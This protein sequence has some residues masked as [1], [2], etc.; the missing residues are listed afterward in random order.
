MTT[1]PSIPELIRR[2]K[3]LAALDLI[4]SP[5][6]DMR[7][8]SFNSTWSAS[9]QMA[10]MRDGCG[11]EWWMVFHAD[12]WTALKG[13]GHESP[14]WSEGGDSLSIALQQTFPSELAEFSH[15]PAFRWDSTS[16]AAFCLPA[17]RDWVWSKPLTQFSKL[18]GGEDELLALLSGSPQD[19]AD[20]ASQYYEADVPVK[21]VQ[22]VFSL[23]PITEDVVLA[24]NPD[25]DFSAIE[26]ELFE[27]IAYPRFTAEKAEA[28]N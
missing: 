27:E 22:Q 4:M 23:S 3:A 10:S 24:L 15:E 25:A 6:W 28:Q 8:Y 11:D 20:F 1:L 26:A 9:Q 17:H 19:Y 7:Y 18:D 14:A 12:G 5:D 16:F 2:T 13:L 21:I